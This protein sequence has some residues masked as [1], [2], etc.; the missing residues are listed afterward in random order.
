MCKG[1]LAMRHRACA[2]EWSNFKGDLACDICKHEIRNLPPIDPAILAARE[3]ARRRRMPN[4]N[5]SSQA[6]CVDFLFDGIRVAWLVVIGCILFRPSYPM[7][8]TF[9]LGGAVGA[10]YVALSL[11]LN[12]ITRAWRA[13]RQRQQEE[14]LAAE[15]AAHAAANSQLQSITTEALTQAAAA[16]AAAQ[17][18]VRGGRAA[19]GEGEGMYALTEPLLIPGSADNV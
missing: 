15:A 4:F 1:E 19:R 11:L 5:T 3:E 18:S 13:R 17:R 7:S 16:A 8:Q 6:T 12:C 2:I 9:I 14:Q 10:L